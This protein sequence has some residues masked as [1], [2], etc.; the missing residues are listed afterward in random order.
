MAVIEQKSNQC[1]VSSHQVERKLEE[2]EKALNFTKGIVVFLTFAAGTMIPLL[3]F[4]GQSWVHLTLVD[5]EKTTVHHKDYYKY[6]NLKGPN[7]NAS[8]VPEEI[9]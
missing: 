8:P 5:H 3:I 2:L 9:K 4:A 7:P 1:D 6:P